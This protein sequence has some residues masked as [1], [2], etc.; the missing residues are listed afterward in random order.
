MLK[1]LALVLALG[2]AL[3]G[4][5]AA[6]R[7]YVASRVDFVPYEERD[8]DIVPVPEDD[9]TVWMG[10]IRRTLKKSGRLNT[11]ASLWTA[12]SVALSGISALLGALAG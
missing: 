11:E 3:T 7:W 9:V 10:A 2:G 1:T 4:I 12:A 8:G 5:V 6:W